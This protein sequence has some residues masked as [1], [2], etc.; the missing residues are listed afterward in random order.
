MACVH[1]T[2]S[3]LAIR[4]RTRAPKGITMFKTEW[5]VRQDVSVYRLKC[6]ICLLGSIEPGLVQMI[7]SYFEDDIHKYGGI[8]VIYFQNASPTLWMVNLDTNIQSIGAYAFAN[9]HS[10]EHCFVKEGLC[11]IQLSSFLRCYNLKR[12][13]LPKSLQRIDSKAF[14][15]CTALTTVDFTGTSIDKIGSHAFK[16]C[17]SLRKI[18][19]PIMESIQP[20]TFENCTRLTQVDIQPGLVSIYPRAFYGCAVLSIIHFPE[21]LLYIDREAFERCSFFGQHLEFPAS[22]ELIDAMAFDSCTYLS[23]IHF[24]SPN[25]RIADAAFCN[26]MNLDSVSF[27]PSTTPFPTAD[28]DRRFGCNIFRNCVHLNKLVLPS[29]VVKIPAFMFYHTELTTITLPTT[30]TDIGRGAFQNCHFLK[31]VR[32]GHNIKTIDDFSFSQCRQLERLVFLTSPAFISPSAFEESDELESVKLI[33]DR[34]D[35]GQIHLGA[36]AVTTFPNN[37]K[38]T[39]VDR[40]PRRPA[41][42]TRLE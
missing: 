6:L 33:P 23:S 3:P 12:I 28:I 41:K 5:G 37:V 4:P 15:Y 30:V 22:L 40:E 8:P 25:T 19:L 14:L 34:S 9:C 24:R 36:F 31:T 35:P 18:V 20:G 26:C 38:L 11:V 13:K 10:L 7:R 39:I 1:K 29:D 42:K 16:G 21:G 32:F 17:T 27:G 2:V